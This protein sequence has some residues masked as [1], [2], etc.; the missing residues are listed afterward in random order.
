MEPGFWF[1]LVLLVLGP[2]L[3]AILVWG[4]CEVV[5]RIWYW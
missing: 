1:P 5:Y 2:P 3:F 4:C